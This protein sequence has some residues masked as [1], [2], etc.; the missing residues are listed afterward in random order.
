MRVKIPYK[1]ILIILG[2]IALFIGCLYPATYLSFWYVCK[3]H[4]K[5]PEVR[6][7]DS[8]AIG[9]LFLLFSCLLYVIALF[10]IK[11]FMKNSGVKR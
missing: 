11:F 10:L 3:I 5:L 8:P 2:K 9:G 7:I 4:L 6:F 1:R